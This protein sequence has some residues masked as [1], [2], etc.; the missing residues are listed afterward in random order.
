MNDSPL[1]AAQRKRLLR[2]H[3]NK[4]RTIAIVDLLESDFQSFRR[5]VCRRLDRDLD[6]REAIELATGEELNR[7]DEVR[8]SRRLGL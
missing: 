4:A 5:R 6:F 1:I 7:L 8:D 3:Y 2:W